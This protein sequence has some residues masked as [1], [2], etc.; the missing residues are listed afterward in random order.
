MKYDYLIG[1]VKQHETSRIRAFN[2]PQQTNL[3]SVP[4]AF[5]LLIPEIIR[6]LNRNLNEICDPDQKVVIFGLQPA[7]GM[8]TSS[9]P[10]EKA[11]FIKGLWLDYHFCCTLDFFKVKISEGYEA[12]NWHCTDSV[13]IDF[14]SGEIMDSD[15]FLAKLEGISD[16]NKLY[17]HIKEDLLNMAWKIANIKQ[18]KD[19]LSIREVA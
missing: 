10:F 13:I 1:M 17:G 19:R 7:S 9:Q 12:H 16:K 4:D 18:P 15:R 2:G 11:R 5:A 3:E 6:I 8:I 14:T